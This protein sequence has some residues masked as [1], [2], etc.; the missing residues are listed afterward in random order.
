MGF[1]LELSSAIDEA[2]SVYYKDENK[3]P[4]NEDIRD[5]VVDWMCERF[6]MT[7]ESADKYFWKYY[8][9]LISNRID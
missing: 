5:Y 8:K 3:K 7:E 9:H 2:Y 1:N 6:D 4:S